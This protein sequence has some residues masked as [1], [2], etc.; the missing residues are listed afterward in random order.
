MPEEPERVVCPQCGA[1]VI[2]PADWRV[3]QCPRCGT[4]ITRMGSDDRYD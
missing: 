2:A 4:P 1:L 3:L